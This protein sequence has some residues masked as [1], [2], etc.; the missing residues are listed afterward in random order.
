[1][2]KLCNNE[3]IIIYYYIGFSIVMPLLPIITIIAYF[4]VFETGQ[5][6][7]EIVEE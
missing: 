1:M 5:R 7:D 3:S 6:A 2:A 4:Y